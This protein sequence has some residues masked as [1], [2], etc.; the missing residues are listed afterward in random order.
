MS[1]RHGQWEL[2]GHDSDPV[3]ADPDDIADEGRHYRRVASG[4]AEQVARLRRLADPEE[5]LKGHYA[6]GLSEA[7]SDLAD[8]LDRI[9]GRFRVVG[10]QLT[11]WDGDVLDARSTTGSA[12]QDAEDAHRDMQRNEPVHRPFG[13]ELTPEQEAADRERHQ[14]YGAASHRLDEARGRARRAMETLDRRA[15]QVAS[16]I[17]AAADDDMKDSTWDKVKGAVG[18]VAKVLDAIADVLGWIGTALTIAALFIP[19]LNAVV[20]M[21]IGI[22]ALVG[23]LGLHT[24]LASTGHGSWLDVGLDVLAI[25]T[26]G[27]GSTAAA[28]ARA[29]RAVTLATAGRMSGRAA[30][31]RVLA[32]RSFNGGRGFLGGTHALYNQLFSRTTRRAMGQAYDDAFRS[33]TQRSL[34][35]TSVLEALKAGGDHSLA[36]LAKDHR[37]LTRQLGEELVDPAYTR[38]LGRALA[39]TRTSLAVDLGSKA[40]NPK[41]GELEG[42]RV[43][44]YGALSDGLRIT[45]GGPY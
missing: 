28:G 36:A 3:P 10:E 20:L 31:S 33:W 37:L 9:E 40:M 15:D 18:K 19:G 4:I 23:A 25:A 12:L 13:A 8:H 41:I 22:I 32:Q 30:S 6:D 17:R 38:N 42:Y 45:I 7:C 16:R 27:I 21:A 1:R 34:P 11:E 43:G 29:G 24:L 44:P 2:L 39:A 35:Q 5:R 14:R 26:L